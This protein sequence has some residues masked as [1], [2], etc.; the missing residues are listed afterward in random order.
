VSLSDVVS[1]GGMTW[2]PIVGLVLFVS[3]F[4]L[5]MAR[6]LWSM[7]KAEHAAAAMMPLMEERAA[8][9]RSSAPME[10]KGKVTP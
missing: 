6:A 7:R 8:E 4:A 9:S 10:E 3:V 1:R 2:L 5:V